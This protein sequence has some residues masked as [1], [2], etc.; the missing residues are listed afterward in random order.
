MC[1]L[2]AK[3]ANSTDKHNTYMFNVHF[4]FIYFA[5]VIVIVGEG[6]YFKF[7]LLNIYF[8]IA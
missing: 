3:F 5:I 4:Y 1:L 7:H 2:C 8:R 6:F